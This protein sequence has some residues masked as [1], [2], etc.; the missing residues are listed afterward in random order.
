MSL[1]YSQANTARH[2]L[3]Y[4]PTPAGQGRF[5]H[6]YP[7]SQYVDEVEGALDRVGFEIQAQE[8]EVSPDHQ[9]FFGALEIAPRHY[10]AEDPEYSLLVGVRGSH[11]QS[12]PHGLVLGSRVMVCSNLA[13]SGNIGSLTTKQTTHISR[14]L[15]RLLNDTVARIP[16]LAQ[17]QAEKFDAYHNYE[18][19]NPR[20]GDAAL[21]E[22]FRQGGLS[23]AQLGKAIREW[24]QPSYQ[25]HAS[26]GRSAW[27]LFNS[28][29]EALKP[30]GDHVNHNL[31]AQRTEIAD[32]FLSNLVGV[33]NR[34]Q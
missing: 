23:A 14:R 12:I 30:A 21:V 24:D 9:R 5:H 11:D 20:A 18:F 29:T 10:S 3:Q 2:E 33:S 26:H 7:F 15:P 34:L 6:P 19:N 16:E 13:F 17:A 32:R 31:I 8:F 1:L 22:I 4:I 28:V 25:E 27:L